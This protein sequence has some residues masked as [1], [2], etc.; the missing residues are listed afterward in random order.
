MTLNKPFTSY[1]V[2]IICSEK[3]QG[4]AKVTSKTASSSVAKS[5]LFIVRETWI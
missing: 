3:L 4:N 1:S 5:L 2:S